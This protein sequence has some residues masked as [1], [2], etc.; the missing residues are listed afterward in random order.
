MHPIVSNYIY[1]NI[2]Q[3]D[4]KTDRQADRQTDRQMQRCNASVMS[5]KAYNIL[6]GQKR[7]SQLDTFQ[8]FVYYFKGSHC[9]TLSGSTV[10]YLVLDF[11]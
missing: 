4:R 2:G 10:V 8:F 11:S 6:G 3:T 5:R 1:E 7:S 9:K